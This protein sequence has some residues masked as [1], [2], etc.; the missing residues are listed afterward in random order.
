MTVHLVGAGP[1]DPEL[2]TVRGARLLSVAD[3]V[4]H[5][6][7]AGPFS[8]RQKGAEVIDVGKLAGLG[9]G[10][11]G[12]DQRHPRRARPAR[13]LRRP[14]EGRRPVRVRP[15]SRGGRGARTAG[16]PFE[17]VPGVTSALRA[18]AVAGIPLTARGTARSFTV[19]TGHEDPLSIPAH[20]WRAMADLA[21]TIVVL[22]GG[23][24]IAGI[25][26]RLVEAGLAS[27]TPVA[28]IHA[29]TTT[30]QSVYVS[31]LGEIGKTRHRS[32]VTFVIGDVV[33]RRVEATG[34][35]VALG[36]G[37]VRDRD[38]TTP[39][40]FGS[41]RRISVLRLHRAGAAEKLRPGRGRCG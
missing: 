32:P 9:T 25:A 17:V 5:D 38:G 12:R 14:P 16:V 3:V 34:S 4:V 15:R 11:P 35:P 30:A 26:D 36:S 19:L 29:A 33:R 18:P 27:R 13:A 40:R 1:G 37:S 10:P 39:Y 6:R 21:G 23:A 8:A 24:R 7:L 41:T 31:S 28:A 2:I 20:R 22:M